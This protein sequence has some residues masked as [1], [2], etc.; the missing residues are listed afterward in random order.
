MADI[1]DPAVFLALPGGSLTTRS[2]LGPCKCGCVQ[3]EVAEAKNGRASLRCVECFS[4][5]R[6]PVRILGWVDM[7]THKVTEAP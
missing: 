6:S 3:F 2:T 7:T 1:F 4:R 5:D